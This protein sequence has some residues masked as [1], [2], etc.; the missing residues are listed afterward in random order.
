MERI[1]KKKAVQAEEGGRAL[2]C[3]APW[4]GVTDKAATSCLA[5]LPCQS[6]TEHPSALPGPC[7]VLVPL[8]GG[9]PVGIRAACV[10]CLSPHAPLLGS[11]ACSEEE[12]EKLLPSPSAPFC[13]KAMQLVGCKSHPAS[14]CTTAHLPVGRGKGDSG[15]SS[16][17]VTLHHSFSPSSVFPA[18]L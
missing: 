17:G 12:E 6:L 4:F 11:D 13:G 1:K 7:W 8:V 2:S 15:C 14:P 9:S 16:V 10:G 3:S 5:P 18:G